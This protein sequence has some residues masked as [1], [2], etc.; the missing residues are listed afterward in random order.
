MER[1]GGLKP[2]PKHMEPIT[3]KKK[4]KR[5]LRKP[6][7]RKQKVKEGDC[8]VKLLS[9][10]PF[11]STEFPTLGQRGRRRRGEGKKGEH[12][13]NE[14]DVEKEE[15]KKKRTD[16]PRPNY[17]VS[18]PITSQ[19]IKHGVEELQ[20]AVVQKDPRLS[21][22]LIPVGTLHITLLVAHLSTQ[23]QIDTYGDGV[24]VDGIRQEAWRSVQRCDV[25]TQ[26]E[27]DLTEQTNDTE[28]G[29]FARVRA[30]GSNRSSEWAV[31]DRFR[32]FDTTL[33]PPQLNVTVVENT[34]QVKLSGPFRWRKDGKK[35]ES[36]LN[37]F[38]HMSYHISIYNN[39]KY[40]SSSTSTVGFQSP[41]H[42]YIS[43]LT[44]P[45]HNFPNTTHHHQHLKILS[46]SHPQTS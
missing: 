10:L 13:E 36:M 12:V 43:I 21:K 33:G 31:T 27:C 24:Y 17:F 2:S 30:N 37:F 41:A 14:E 11:S 4:V 3:V 46:P 19:K 28:E 35:Q 25:I 5:N 39:S 45:H 9:E 42:L 38:S 26:T 1:D 23:E 6:R 7:G 20:A 18:I 8:M 44:H 34:L 40:N 15:K 32:L 29:Y 16:V 22:A